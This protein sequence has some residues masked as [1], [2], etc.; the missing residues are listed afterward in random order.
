M[1]FEEGKENIHPLSLS[2]LLAMHMGVEAPHLDDSVRVECLMEGRHFTVGL[3][4]FFLLLQYFT[5]LN[6]SN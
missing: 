1:Q 5:A 3:F 2:I 4:F 6:R